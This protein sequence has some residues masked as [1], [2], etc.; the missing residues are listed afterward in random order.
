M[1]FL[2]VLRKG[3]ILDMLEKKYDWAIWWRIKILLFMCWRE[4]KD[5]YCL[6]PDSDLPCISTAMPLLPYILPIFISQHQAPPVFTALLGW[7]GPFRCAHTAFCF[8]GQ[9]LSLQG[10]VALRHTKQRPLSMAFSLVT[11]AIVTLLRNK[12]E[13][14]HWPLLKMF[15]SDLGFI[16]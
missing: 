7:D 1:V 10:S 9:R 2:S 15:W 16:I 6:L 8:H 11:L 3:N 14:D 13:V 4:K 12:G 5:F